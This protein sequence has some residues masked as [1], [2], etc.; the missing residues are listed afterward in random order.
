MKRNETIELNGAEYTLE[1]NR[2]SAVKIEERTNLSKVVENARES[3]IEYIDEIDDNEDPFADDTT[4][5]N[6]IEKM[7]EK[8]KN[9]QKVISVAFY[10]WLYPNHHLKYSKVK[11]SIKI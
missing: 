8:E 7:E 11:E 3:L 6:I 2:D 1:L 4:L 9:L 10:I 5:D